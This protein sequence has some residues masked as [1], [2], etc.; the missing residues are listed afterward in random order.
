MPTNFVQATC[1]NRP[2]IMRLKRCAERI[3]LEEEVFMHVS[4][5]TGVPRRI[6]FVVCAIIFAL[7]LAACGGGGTSSNSTPTP[8]ATAKPS[9][10]TP[11]VTPTPSTTR[12][13]G[14]GFSIAYPQGW[15]VNTSKN[16]EVDFVDPTRNYGL[17]VVYTP[18]PGG[19]ASP[20]TLMTAEYNT[21]KG[22]VKN[23]QAKSVPSPVTI[24]GDKWLQRALTGEVNISGQDVPG[25]I[26]ILADV[27][28]AHS[29]SSTSYSILFSG[30]GVGFDAMNANGFQPMLQSFKFTS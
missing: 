21:I 3:Y 29:S 20:D 17:I 8:T 22:S 5:S 19:L 1:A 15:Q 23:P 2:I 14:H 16:N 12:Y 6:A 11:P 4:A 10:T 7:L 9:P 26:N 24:G 18:D 30:P 27:H 13:T 25:Q 28:P